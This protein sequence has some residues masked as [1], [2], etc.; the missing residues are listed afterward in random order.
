[1]ITFVEVRNFGTS[2][3]LTLHA[4]SVTLLIHEI[5]FSFDEGRVNTTM[6]LLRYK[7][8][9]RRWLVRMEGIKWRED[10]FCTLAKMNILLTKSIQYFVQKKAMDNT[11]KNEYFAHK[12]NT[13]FRTKKSDGQHRNYTWVEGKSSTS[14]RT[15]F[16]SQSWTMGWRCMVSLPAQFLTILKLFPFLCSVFFFVFG[17]IKSMQIWL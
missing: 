12:I 16:M 3:Q 9:F 14:E 11:S 6:S 10:A 1:M 4:P 2:P 15:T 8:T 17:K 5:W 7:H 13:I